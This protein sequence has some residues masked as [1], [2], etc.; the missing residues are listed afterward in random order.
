MDVGEIESQETVARR[1]RSF[2]VMYTVGYCLS[3]AALL[4]AL[5]VLLGLSR[6]HCTRTYIHMNL[7][8][9]FVLKAT[10]VLAIDA[11]LRARY[12]QRVG[13]DLSVSVW[14]SDGAVTGC[15]V[16]TVLMQYSVVANYG[17]LLVE[18]LY[19][20]RLLGCA[21]FPRRSCFTL[22]LGIGWGAPVLFVV[23]WAVA[24]GLFENVQCW[25]SNDNM[26]LWW[27]LRVP[28]FLAI[29][30]NFF[31]FVH[32]LHTL[33]A[34][35]RAHQIRSSDHKFRLAKSTLTLIP[36][37][38]VHEVVFAFVT[39]EHAQG[40]LRAAKLFFDLFLS[41]FQG[42]LVAVLY[43]FL[44]KEVQSELLRRWSRW[45]LGTALWEERAPSSHAASARPP[46][47]PSEKLLLGRGSSSGSSN[48]AGQDPSEVTPVASL[49]SP[50]A[51]PEPPPGTQLGLD[52]CPRGHR[53]TAQ[54]RMPHRAGGE[55]AP[56]WV[57]RAPALVV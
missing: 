32:V 44:N 16:A 27:I 14:L 42:L 18:G 43:C 1:Y 5:A 11:L 51:P 6:L 2:Q 8:A 10:S 38:G 45:R 56:P 36:L 4:L 13:N 33:A 46:G 21:T 57:C 7:F 3:L 54:E 28:V 52:G 31:V 55:G 19:L 15:R 24:K 34:K 9:A 35:L 23:P 49:G 25:T 17:W 40:T 29:L 48:R 20:R 50:G 37:L 26:G 39:D 22:Y 30:I 47:T 53:G 12:S 41:S